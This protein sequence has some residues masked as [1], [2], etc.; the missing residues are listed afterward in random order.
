MSLIESRRLKEPK[1]RA[2]PRLAVILGLSSILALGIVGALTAYAIAGSG[3]DDSAQRAA[4]ASATTIRSE[5]T[6]T[7]PAVTTTTAEP[8][9]TTGETKT[10]TSETT[11]STMP[12][13]PTTTAAAQPKTTVSQAYVGKGYRMMT[14]DITIPSPHC[15]QALLAS[16]R[17]E[18]G[19][20]STNIMRKNAN[21]MII[22]NPG[23]VTK[24]RLLEL[25]AAV[26]GSELID[27]REV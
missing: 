2:F 20:L 8:T 5:T 23:T 12:A 11:T 17:K 22:Y 19:V 9:T 14:L 1:P 13:P 25:T 4:P 7:Q 21:N 16:I 26:G 18:P 24:E 3:G 10:S 6:T 27:D 15:E